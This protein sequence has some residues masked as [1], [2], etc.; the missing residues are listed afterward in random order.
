MLFYVCFCSR[1]AVRSFIMMNFHNKK[2]KRII[3]TIIVIITVI[4]FVLPLILSYFTL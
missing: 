1:A 2:T 3:A 4:A